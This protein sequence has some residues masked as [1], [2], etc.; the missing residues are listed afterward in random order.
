MEE[1]KWCVYLLKCSD[2]TLYCGITNDFEKRLKNHNNKTGAKYTKYRTPVSLLIKTD[3]IYSKSEASKIEYQV[4]S[5]PKKLKQSFLQ[6][7]CN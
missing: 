6:T 2:E 1:K 7:F 4:K 5:Q 3:N